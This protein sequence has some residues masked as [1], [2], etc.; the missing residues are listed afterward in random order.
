MN[1]NDLT[2]NYITTYL[3]LTGSAD[4]Q[5]VLPNIVANAELRIYRELDFLMARTQNSTL[6]LDPGT[7]KVNLRNLTGTV[8]GGYPIAQTNPVV[9][10]GVSVSKSNIQKVATG[11]RVRLQAVSLELMEMVYPNETVRG[12]PTY[13]CMLDDATLI[14]GPTAD[15]AYNCEI[16]GS[17]RPA[18]MS[19]TQ[20]NSWLGDNL[21]D[22]LFYA[23]MLEMAGYQ[24]N[25]GA[26]ASDPQQAMSWKAQYD[27]AK[28]GA[29][30]EETRRKQNAP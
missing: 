27:A 14:V 8:I 11:G 4:Y 10:H 13:F 12:F 25:Y 6:S 29:Q 21:P 3:E 22:L 19:P 1:W 24:Q 7:R 26:A 18:A 5:D 28:E 16:T 9:V 15:F 23:A 2:E 30:A 17:W 20:L